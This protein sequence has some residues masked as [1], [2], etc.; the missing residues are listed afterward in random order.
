PEMTPVIFRWYARTGDP[1]SRQ[2]E[3]E[4][5]V[6]DVARAFETLLGIS[7]SDPV[8]FFCRIGVSRGP[9]ARSLRLPIDDLMRQ[10][11]G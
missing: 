6:R 9:T 10:R 4:S 7:E 11:A 1:I 3:V 2:A 5:G 8:G